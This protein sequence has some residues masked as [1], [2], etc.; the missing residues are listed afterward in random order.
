[1]QRAGD[2]ILASILLLADDEV[3]DKEMRDAA[4]LLVAPAKLM[5]MPR[6][7]PGTVIGGRPSC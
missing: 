3:R 4:C 6:A 5:V 1:M 2:P 7:M